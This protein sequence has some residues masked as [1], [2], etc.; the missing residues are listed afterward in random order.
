MIGINPTIY[1]ATKPATGGTDIHRTWMVIL[2]GGLHL[3]HGS[4]GSRRCFVTTFT[5]AGIA[6]WTRASRRSDTDLRDSSARE[7][8][9][10]QGEAF[11][12]QYHTFDARLHNVLSGEESVESASPSREASLRHPGLRPRAWAGWARRHVELCRRFGDGDDTPR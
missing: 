11:V 12:R 4:P 1:T 10:K 8:I 5:V 7:R 9:R 3:G 6:T 2:G